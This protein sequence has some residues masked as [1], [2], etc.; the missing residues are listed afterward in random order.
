MAL[1]W[2][3]KRSSSDFSFFANNALIFSNTDG[4]FSASSTNSNSVS[5]AAVKMLSAFNLRAF[6]PLCEKLNISV[7]KLAG[8][9]V[10]AKP[11]KYALPVSAKLVSISTDV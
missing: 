9:S 5:T 8:L 10:T 6:K 3:E 1:D 7:P 11:T 4:L 2:S